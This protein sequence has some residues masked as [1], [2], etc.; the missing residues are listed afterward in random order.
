MTTPQIL[1]DIIELLFA[2]A[3]PA[4][5]CTLALAGMA[6]R[7][8]T[9]TNFEVGGRFQRWIIWTTIFLTLP[10]CLSW[11]LAQVG[12]P[13]PPP[14]VGSAWL[15]AAESG[16]NTFVSAVLVGK[17]LP[18][19]AAYL[20]LKAA[21]DASQGHNPLGSV[22]SAIFLLS[23]SGTMQ[24]LKSWNDQT[25]MATIDVLYSLWNYAAGTI[26]PEAA[27]F[28]VVGA[29]INY[30]RQKPFMPLVMTALAFLSVSGLWQLVQAMAR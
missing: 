11:F 18:L 6:L 4:A 19:C 5:V 12:L 27:G 3:A 20:V 25:Q 28:A 16:F 24:L 8:E 9:G 14:G 22:L 30:S 29:V 1:T 10:Q 2:L 17:L 7:Q 13:T 23:V 21:L 26:L 15:A